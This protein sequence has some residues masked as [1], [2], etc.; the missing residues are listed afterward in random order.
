[1]VALS[2]K[3]LQEQAA[4]WNLMSPTAV[5]ASLDLRYQASFV[6]LSTSSDF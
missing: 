5:Q 6:A 3:L 4:G 1:M 2:W